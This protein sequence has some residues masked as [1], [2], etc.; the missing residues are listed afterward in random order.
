MFLGHVISKNVCMFLFLDV[1]IQDLVENFR[2]VC[3]VQSAL[4]HIADDF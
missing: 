2:N 3:T 1:F 4:A